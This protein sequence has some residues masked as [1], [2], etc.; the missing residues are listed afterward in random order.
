MARRR[1]KRTPEENEAISNK[2][3]LLMSEGYPL[4]QATAIAFRMFRD[5]ELTI[6]DETSIQYRRQHPKRKSLLSQIAEA[7]RLLKLGEKL[8]NKNK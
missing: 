4:E 1:N 3:D 2:V 8:I 6:K 7:A 5:G